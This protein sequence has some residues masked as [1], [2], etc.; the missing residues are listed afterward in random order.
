MQK[1]HPIVAS[2]LQKLPDVLIAIS[3]A[4]IMAGIGFTFRNEVALIVPLLTFSS[5]ATLAALFGALMP[6]W[7]TAALY[8]VGL[9]SLLF[10]VLL[11][12]IKA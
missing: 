9:I 1:K 6:V 5:F 7:I 8:G 3:C 2:F 4:L 10:F 12:C 11:A